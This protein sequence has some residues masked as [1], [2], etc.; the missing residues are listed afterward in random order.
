MNAEWIVHEGGR[1]LLLFF[2]GWG[3][4]RRLADFV[5]SEAQVWPDRDIVVLYDYRDLD[6]PGWLRDAMAGYRTVDLLAWSL[7]VWA[8]M[9]AGLQGIRRAVAINGTPFPVDAE[10]GISPEIFRGT[11][12][13]WSDVS[14]KR[15][16]RRMFNGCSSDRLDVVR[17]ERSSEDQKEEL[18]S[19]G[20][21]VSR[22]AGSFAPAWRFSKVVIGGQDLV[23]LPENQRRAW[24]GVP[25]S[26][27]AQM[28]HFPFFH[29]DGWQ[30]VPE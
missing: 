29:M 9:N 27:I 19:I 16:E 24:Q 20:S 21:A 11:L 30:E 7:G 2:N 6:L 23:F 10:L 8:A 5:Q 28:P 18:R 3:M 17:S 1:D 22:S 25:V 15:F 4:D 26:E 13:N 12:E 14:R